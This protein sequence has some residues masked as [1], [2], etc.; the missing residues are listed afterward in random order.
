[1]YGNANLNLSNKGSS[2]KASKIKSEVFNG[3]IN[4]G[5]FEVSSYLESANFNFEGN[6]SYINW[7][8]LGLS[9]NGLIKLKDAQI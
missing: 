9:G 3:Y 6:K 1:M 5:K 7:K 8:R 4:D 2:F